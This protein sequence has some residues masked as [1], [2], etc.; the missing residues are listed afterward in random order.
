MLRRR[1]V[2]LLALAIVFTS[3]P[4]YAQTTGW[5]IDPDHTRVQFAVSHMRTST[6]R[7][8]FNKTTGKVKWDGRDF[9]SA[10][11]EIVADVA[12]IDTGVPNRDAHLRTADFMLVDKYP[13]ITF[14]SV[15]IEPAGPGRLWMTGNLTIR[16]VTKQVVLDVAGPSKPVKGPDGAIHVG[17]SATATI[18]RRDFG[19]RWNRVLEAGGLLVGFDVAITIDIEIVNRGG[20][21][22]KTAD[23]R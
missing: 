19:I 8:R 9:A 2:L 5:Q 7:G 23:H 18:D 6:V 4:L 22:A 14:K 12:S 3:S 1:P 20:D 10:S 21:T 16:G 17:A 15:K 11:V 13:T